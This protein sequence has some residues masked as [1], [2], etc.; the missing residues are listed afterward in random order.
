MRTSYNISSV[1]MS[2]GSDSYSSPCDSDSRKATIDNLKAARIATVISSGNGAYSGA[3]GSPGCISTAVTV[4]GD[5]RGRR[6]RDLFE[7]RELP[8]P[9]APGSSITSSIPGTGYDAW[10]GTSMAA[11]H[12]TGAW[13]LLKQARPGDTVDQILASFTSTGLS[14]TDGLQVQLRDQEADQ[15]IRGAKR[16]AYHVA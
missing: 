14:V 4:G 2:L 6:G 11:P 13:A 7:Q 9:P 10:D 12:V 16:C 15:R 8:V 3:I 1:N 5:D